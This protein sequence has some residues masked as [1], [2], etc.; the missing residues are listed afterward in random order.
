MTDS[1]TLPSLSVRSSVAVGPKVT[2]SWGR[3]RTDPQNASKPGP[4]GF[5]SII[6]NRGA[7]AMATKR[8][9][10][11]AWSYDANNGREMRDNAP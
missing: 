10:R 9:D 6:A 8:D 11:C 5:A 1:A 3:E 7:S 2:S 4:M